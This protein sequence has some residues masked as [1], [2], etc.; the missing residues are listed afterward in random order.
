MVKKSPAWVQSL[1][2]EDPLEKEM[3][4]HSSILAC[5]LPWTQE[6]GGYSPWVTQSRTWLSV[7]THVVR[8]YLGNTWQ[9]LRPGAAAGS[10]WRW[11]GSPHAP[12]AAPGCAGCSS[13][14]TCEWRG[15]TPRCRGSTP[16]PRRGRSGREFR[17]WRRWSKARL[18]SISFKHPQARAGPPARNASSKR[19]E[20][21]KH[22]TSLQKEKKKLTFWKNGIVSLGHPQG[23]TSSR[24]S[25]DLGPKGRKRAV[26]IIPQEYWHSV[27][28]VRDLELLNIDIHVTGLENLPG[29]F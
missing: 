28:E 16:E 9:P 27:H 2:Q 21:L 26:N 15:R 17:P 7:P 11:S 22:V 10:P 5:R 12:S 19:D 25:Y 24:V 1:G 14:W 8:G 4:T 3:A 6:P 20:R 18:P 29:E 23:L 13:P